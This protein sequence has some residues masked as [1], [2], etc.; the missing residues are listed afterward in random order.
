MLRQGMAGKIEVEGLLLVLKL[1]AV[2][3]LGNIGQSCR[4]SCRIAVVAGENIEE[5]RLPKAAVLLDL[6]GSLQRL[7]QDMHPLIAAGAEAIQGACLDKPLDGRA[8]N[9][10]QVDA[11]AEVKEI[12][13]RSALAA[14][15][16][17]LLRRT[18]ANALDGRQ[19]K[20]DLAVGD[21]KVY[22]SGIDVWRQHVHAKPARVFDVLNQIVTF[23]AVLDFTGQ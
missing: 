7:W 10:L 12:L 3:P 15:A 21:R 16:D 9:D 2:G 13:E 5:I 4:H 11:L 18:T 23:V 1:L 19:A 20:E 6:A 14:C 17:D 8:R 22:L